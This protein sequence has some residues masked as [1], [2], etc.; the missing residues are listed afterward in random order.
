MVVGFRDDMSVGRVARGPDVPRAT[1]R[2]M[3]AMR[4][5]CRG[6]GVERA[7]CRCCVVMCDVAV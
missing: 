7:S 4:P 6:P 5:R 3:D 2:T 1:C